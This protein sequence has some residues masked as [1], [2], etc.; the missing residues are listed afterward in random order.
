MMIFFAIKEEVPNK[1]IAI[2]VPE[3]GAVFGRDMLVLWVISG[4]ALLFCAEMW[5]VLVR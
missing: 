3:N 4:R 5:S 2:P 1:G